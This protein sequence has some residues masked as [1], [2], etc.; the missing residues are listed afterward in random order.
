MAPLV[1]DQEV[2]EVNERLG[3]RLGGHLNVLLQEALLL[4]EMLVQ[5]VEQILFT[6]ASSDQR[7][8]HGSDVTACRWLHHV[9]G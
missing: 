6:G 8:A 7:I 5:V 3:S 4:L 9:A 1:F 2:H